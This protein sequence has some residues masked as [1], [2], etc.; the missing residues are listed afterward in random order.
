MSRSTKGEAWQRGWR[1]RLHDELA[2][3]GYSSLMELS[4][5]FPAASYPEL[6]NLLEMPFAPIQVMWCL[7]EEFAER[8]DMSG[9]ALDALTRYLQ[10]YLPMNV[11]DS[12]LSRAAAAFGAWSAAMGD[13]NRAAVNAVGEQLRTIMAGMETSG[14]LGRAQIE[15]LVNSQRWAVLPTQQSRRGEG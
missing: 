15:E 12:L 13:E 7:R 5:R 8:G 6:A 14:A 9:F 11:P 3:N 10:E 2:R 1:V 4:Q